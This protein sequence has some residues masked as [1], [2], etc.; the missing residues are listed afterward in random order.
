MTTLLAT[1]DAD[2]VRAQDPKNE[3]TARV[4]A[5]S[6]IGV[7]W[8]ELRATIADLTAR[9]ATTERNWSRLFA[10][11]DRKH[12]Y[13]RDRERAAIAR[14]ETAERERDAAHD[15]ARMAEDRVARAREAARRVAAWDGL[16][17]YADMPE[18][19]I[20]VRNL[21]DALDVFG[22]ETE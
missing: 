16:L 8:P 2:Y 1:C 7:A 3:G 17:H 19:A 9:L 18:V 10:E 22:G 14:A 4:M 21:R 6:A 12:M 15:S 13:S 20:D 5:L 11:S